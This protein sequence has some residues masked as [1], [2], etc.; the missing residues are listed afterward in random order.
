MLLLLATLL[1][2]AVIAKPYDGQALTEAEK[3][4]KELKTLQQEM[5]RASSSKNNAEKT[6]KNLH[7]QRTTTEADIKVLLDR[8]ELVQ[9]RLVNTQKKVDDAELRLYTTIDELEQTKLELEEAL[10][11]LKQ[12]E[13]MMD[14]RVRMAYTSGVSSYLDVLLNA[15]SFSDF[16]GRL[17]TVEAIV[18]QDSDI[19]TQKKQYSEA[20]DRKKQEVEEQKALIEEE[21]AEVK[22]LYVEVQNHK[23]ELVQNEKEKEVMI[24]QIDKEIEHLEEISEEAEKQLMELAQ[25]AS[26][27]EAKKKRIKQYWTGGK[28][29]MPLKDD[30]TLTSKYGYRTHPVTGQK[31]KLH[32]GIDLGAPKGTAVYAAESGVVIVA[33]SWSSYGNAIVIDHGGG[34]WTLYAHLMV[35]GIHV[36]KGDTVKRG[37]KIGSVGSTGVSTGNHLHFEVRK[38]SVAVDPEPYL[39]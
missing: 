1:V 6:V 9:L 37:Q 34:L 11:Q 17:D 16:L 25:K 26:D 18:K 14:A 29:G 8:I 28:L 35:G 19:A 32:T 33:Q 5:N 39:K 2:I 24:A 15:T 10:E 22:A 27:L 23:D 7:G 21:L 31:S 3:I 30:Y 38:D 20:V 4:D 12:R 13:E 36:E